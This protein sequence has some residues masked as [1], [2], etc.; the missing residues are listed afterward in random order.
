MII[1]DALRLLLC[2]WITEVV[3]I[4]FYVHVLL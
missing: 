1:I 2:V 3:V 4:I